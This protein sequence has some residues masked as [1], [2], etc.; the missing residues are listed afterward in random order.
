MDKVRLKKLYQR[1]K[2]K[3]RQMLDH[4]THP[5][6][7]HVIQRCIRS[8]NA[9]QSQQKSVN[10]TRNSSFSLRRRWKSNSGF[11]HI[12]CNFLRYFNACTRG[13]CILCLFFLSNILSDSIWFRSTPVI[14]KTPEFRTCFLLVGSLNKLHIK[15]RVMAQSCGYNCSTCTS[16]L[17][18]K[19]LP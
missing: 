11:L 19:K 2:I 9:K 10:P 1:W 18:L 8:T 14:P 12:L 16:M 3:N 6:Q 5:V 13:V 7:V 4:K 15:M 17:H